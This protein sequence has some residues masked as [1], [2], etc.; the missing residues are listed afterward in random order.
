M[1][2]VRY[3]EKGVNVLMAKFNDISHAETYIGIENMQMEMASVLDDFEKGQKVKWTWGK[4]DGQSEEVEIL[5]SEPQKLAYG[6]DEGYQIKTQSGKKIY[7][8]KS[9]LTAKAQGELYIAK[10]KNANHRN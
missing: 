2:Q 6:N 4:G 8:P 5:K 3:K 9:Q 10:E 1:F 7:V